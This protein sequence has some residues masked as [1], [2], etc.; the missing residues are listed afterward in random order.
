MLRNLKFWIMSWFKPKT[1]WMQ[2]HFC[3]KVSRDVREYSC[4]TSCNV[5][6]IPACRPCFKKNSDD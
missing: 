5:G 4:D 6:F 3:G 2:C 1:E